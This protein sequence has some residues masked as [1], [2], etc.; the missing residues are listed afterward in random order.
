MDRRPTGRE[1]GEIAE[2]SRCRRRAL[3][4]MIFRGKCVAAGIAEGR[5]HVVDVGGWLAT[6][7]ARET[8][9]S[10]DEEIVR[11]EAA[12]GR[13]AR[14]L[15]RVR[16]LLAQRG[17]PQD[18][19]I[20]AAQGT[21]LGDPKL[22]AR[23]EEEIHKNLQSAE[24]AVARVAIEF[25]NTL[26]E[27]DISM[28]RDKAADVLDVGQRLVRCLD[29]SATPEA[30]TADVIVASSV[31]P[32]QLVRYVHQGVIALIVEN[33][34]SKS[35]TAILAR[36][37]GVPMVTGIDGAATR[38]R[39]GAP[40]VIDAAAGLV[41]VDPG[42]ADEETVHR[43]RESKTPTPLSGL[44]PVPKATKDGVPVSILLNISDP[45]EA[46]NATAAGVTGVGLFR[47]EFL[48]MDRASWPEEED[49]FQT[50]RRVSAALGDGELNIRLADFGAEKCP[51]YADIPVNRN[52]SLGIRGIRLLLARPDILDPQVRALARLARLRPL[53]VLLPM[54]DTL[55]T[56]LQIRGELCRICGI[57][58]EEALPF[59]LGTMVEVPSAALLIED[60]IGHIDS[61]SVGLND[62]TQYVL[63]ADRDDESVESYHDPLQPVVLR[64]LHRIVE[65]ANAHGKP[66]TMCGE[67]AGDPKLTALMLAL[68]VRRISVSRSHV[69]RIAAA[70]ANLSISELADLGPAVLGCSTGREVRQLLQARGMIA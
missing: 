46:T 21:L 30:P 48:Y 9:R 8:L 59:R 27:S 42:P 70:L 57:R 65:S 10:A 1:A 56:L 16:H 22:I 66:V 62:L 50:Y 61:V 37:L 20:F 12:R 17:R 7:L 26:K 55:D 58:E 18:A 34:G 38:I 63:A 41:I 49:S 25:H 60:I 3:I 35:H 13:A 15:D 47:T 28:V 44:A 67:L 6:A 51:A 68:G 69:G 33:C 45:L 5:V 29:E 54:I 19:G 2:L 43:I 31:V 52:P 32:S 14:E 11:L 24:A 53:T 39:D 40:V 23:M 64:L 36:G 4:S